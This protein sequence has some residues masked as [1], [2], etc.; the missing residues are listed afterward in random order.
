[1]KYL[2]VHKKNPDENILRIIDDPIELFKTGQLNEAFDKI[3]KIGQEVKIKVSI[4]HVATQRSVDSFPRTK[5][6]LG[7]GDY[8]G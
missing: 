3:Y 7:V 8:R 5:D 4:E 2:W 6:S 1:M